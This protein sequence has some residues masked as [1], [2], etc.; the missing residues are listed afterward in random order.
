[1]PSIETVVAKAPTDALFGPRGRLT[2]FAKEMRVPVGTVF[3]WKRERGIPVW[4]RAKVLDAVRRLRI[5]VPADVIA[6]LAIEE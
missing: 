3:C 6:Y 1:M 4:R 2:L 5:D